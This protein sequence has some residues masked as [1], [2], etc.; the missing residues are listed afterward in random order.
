MIYNISTHPQT[1]VF[2]EEPQILSRVEVDAEIGCQ[3]SDDYSLEMSQETTSNEDECQSPNISSI[4]KSELEINEEEHLTQQLSDANKSEMDVD[5]EQESQ[6][7]IGSSVD[8]MR[9]GIS[10][11]DEE[12][13]FLVPK[14]GTEFESEDHAY[15]CYSRY[16]VLEG[17]SIRKDFVNKSRIDGAVISRRY[18]CYRQGYRPSKHNLN[19]RK[20]RQETRTGC[21][22][23]MTIARQPNGKFCVTH[24][25]TE[26]NHEFVTSSS[27]HLLPSQKRLTF[28]QAVEAELANNSGM[29]GVPKLGMG[30][31]SEDH[32]Y[33]FYNAYAGRVGFSVRKDYVNRSKV[34]GAVA[35]RRFTCFREGFRQKDKRGLNV[36]RPR[37]ETR[38]GCLAQLVISRQP[39]G[40]YRVTHFEEKH[41]HE[42]VA[43]CRVRMLRSQKRSSVSQVFEGNALD[44]SKG[45]SKSTSEISCNSAGDCVD[46]GYDP[47]D[48]K[49]KLSSRRAREMRE[50]EAGKIRQYFQ[51]KKLK[52]PSFFY[53]MQLDAEDQ[54]TNIFWADAKMV[55]D[56]SDFG[57]V[58]CF[59]TTNRLNRDCRPFFPFIGVNHHKQMVIFGA[60]LLYDETV[61]S[62]KWLFQT[63][64]EAMSGKKPKTILSDEDAVLAEAI[65]S[66]IPEIS[67]RVCVWHVY[68]SALKQLSHT[69]L[70]S[71]SFVNDLS[72]CFFDYEEE[73]GFIAAWKVMLDVHCL[74]ENEWLHKMFENRE[75]W[76]IAYRR[77]IFCADIKSAQ[78]CEGFIANLRKHQ[79]P[80]LDILSFFKHLGKVLNDWHYKELEANYEMNQ[81][82]PRLMGDVILLKRARDVYTPTIFDLFQQEYE[83]CLNIVVNECIET[84]T[85]F[86][87]KVSIY[88]QQR[89]Y[90]VTYNLSDQKILCGCMKFEYVGVLC[91]H[92]LKVLDYRNIKLLP[93]QYI[94][95]RWTRD[96]RL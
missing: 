60:A 55:V 23:H 8:V 22:A 47:V 48:Y 53:K 6:S 13:T 70:G 19:V 83:T 44:S 87:Y 57:D 76:A 72:S 26:H 34:N 86:K 89:E 77:D 36:K 56:Y 32:A 65:H 45:Q 90:N 21:L 50:G 62:F 85:S 43:A 2:E 52:N 96:A 37:K 9:S 84:E 63:F 74:W 94:L 68:Q 81:H 49:S 27:A 75:Q 64:L 54:I 91:S 38:I 73:E 51:S 71:P 7:P 30:F 25:E 61:D 28:A 79:K 42:L 46:H 93:S 1:V 31:E 39:D 33:E 80:D 82:M 58:L 16:A 15:R 24:F 20:P 67:H 78:L 35:S 66:V 18:T 40:K 69:F 5:C 41:N 17:F 29:D 14:V 10:V 92:A 11:K 59:D 4:D 12:D 88:G 95:K 3:S